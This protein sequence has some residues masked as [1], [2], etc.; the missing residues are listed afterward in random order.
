VTRPA[1]AVMKE[2]G[3][4]R[5]VMTTSAAG[6]YGNFGQTNYSSAKMALVGLMN[7]LKLEGAKYDIKVNTVAPIAA[8]R[9]MA[10][11]IPPEFLEKMKPEF[12][13]PLVLFL[14]SEQCPATGRIYN[15]GVGF[16]NRAAVMTSPGTVIGDGKRIPTVEEVGAAWEKILSLNG[17]RELGQL[18]DL[19]G[20]MLAAFQDKKEGQS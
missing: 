12:V 16:Y 5:I 2:K 19:M 3:Y 6:L 7:T 10:D 11:V 1:F 15:A 13:S 8:S 14:C 17:A 4:G 18:N 20:D 9:L